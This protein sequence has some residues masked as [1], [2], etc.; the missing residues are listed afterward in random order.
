VN[1]LLIVD[2]NQM[3]SNALA[4]EL[5]EAGY[6]IEQAFDGEEGLEKAKNDKPDIIL[7][8]LMMPKLNGHEVLD[9][10]KKHHDTKNISVLILTASENEEELEKTLRKGAV[11]ALIK[12]KYTLKSIVEKVKELKN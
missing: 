12:S 2:D 4:D 1:K 5:R 3:L 6:D 9:E 8:D 10:L 7:L 11:D